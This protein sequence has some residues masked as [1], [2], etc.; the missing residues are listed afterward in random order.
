LL[1][2]AFSKNA[3]IYRA[4]IALNTIIFLTENIGIFATL[5]LDFE[6]IKVL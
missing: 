6:K 1:G 4:V 5:P 2:Q 3:Q